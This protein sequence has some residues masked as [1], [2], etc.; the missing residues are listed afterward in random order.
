MPL[1][2]NILTALAVSRDIGRDLRGKLLRGKD[3]G[4]GPVAPFS[5]LRFDLIAN[6]WKKRRGIPQ[7]CAV[8]PG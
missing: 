5:A 1:I 2:Q 3:P 6:D 7:R 4:T 8:M